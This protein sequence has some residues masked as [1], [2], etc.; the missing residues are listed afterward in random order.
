MLS[1][2]YEQEQITRNNPNTTTIWT[3]IINPREYDYD[4]GQPS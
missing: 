4:L 2:V 1:R 3:N